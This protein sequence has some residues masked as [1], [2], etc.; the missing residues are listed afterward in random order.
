MFTTIVNGHAVDFHQIPT[1]I[2]AVV[3]GIDVGVY[4]DLVSAWQAAL[5]VARDVWIRC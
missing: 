2:L 4:T 3:S 1:G 5:C